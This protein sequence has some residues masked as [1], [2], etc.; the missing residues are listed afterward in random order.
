M[1]NEKHDLLHEFPEHRDTIH[2]LKMGNPY[3]SRLFDEY[4]SV[5]DE[6]H[7]IETGIENTSDD[8]LE[9]RKKQRLLLKDQLF[10]LIKNS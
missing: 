6:V 4:H 10:E 8:Y 3:F 2:D 9:S 5:E 7:R 1:M